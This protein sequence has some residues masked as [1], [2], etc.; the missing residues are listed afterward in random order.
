MKRIWFS[1]LSTLLLFFLSQPNTSD[2]QSWTPDWT[3]P[4]EMY[5]LRPKFFSDGF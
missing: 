1:L 5:A 4:V 2:S 3:I